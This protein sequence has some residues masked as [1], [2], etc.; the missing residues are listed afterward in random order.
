MLAG[1]SSQLGEDSIENFIA[2]DGPDNWVDTRRLYFLYL[3]ARGGDFS[4]LKIEAMWFAP[5]ASPS[6]I[7]RA[8]LERSLIAS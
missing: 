4:Q 5:I 7:K 2:Q 6:I 8:L 1:L 3:M